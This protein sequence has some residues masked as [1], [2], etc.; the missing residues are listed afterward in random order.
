MAAGASWIDPSNVMGSAFAVA[1][2]PFLLWDA[3]KIVFAA[4]TVT[5]AWSLLHR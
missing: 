5:G 3:L 1:V 2:Q 4:V